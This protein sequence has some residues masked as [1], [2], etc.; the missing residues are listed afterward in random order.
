MLSTNAWTVG[1][2]AGGAHPAQARTTR[3]DA[4]D[5]ITG[6]PDDNI[7]GDGLGS[8]VLRGGAVLGAADDGNRCRAA[9]QV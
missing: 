5:T 6:D 4:D 8:D 7:L 2:G 3:G 9:A 1:T